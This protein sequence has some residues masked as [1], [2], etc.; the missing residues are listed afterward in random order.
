MEPYHLPFM[1]EEAAAPLESAQTVVLP[2]P[3]E[4]GV[5][6][7][8]GTK[9]A[10]D[11]I[12]RASAY[13]ELYDEYLK[14]E[15]FK[16]GI[17]TASPPDIPSTPD[18][19]IKTLY[20]EIQKLTAE[21]KQVLLLGGDHSISVAFVKAL[22]EK[23][24]WLSVIQFDAHADLRD[25]Y[26]DSKM[27]H[28]CVMSRIRELTGDT[29]QIGVRSMCIEE[30]ELIESQSIPVCTMRAFREGSFDLN[31]AINS[32]P[33]PVYITFDVDVFDWSVVRSTGTP[34]PGGMTWDEVTEVLQLIAAV[35]NVVGFDLV[36]LSADENDTPSAFA[37]A[38]LA[39]R[40]I[41]MFSENG[42]CE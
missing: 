2:F 26:E 40:M 8:T 12:L 24:G 41:G 4:G 22:I 37:V 32:L 3:Y 17:F 7:G 34:E 28:A 42:A 23:H 38:K 6:Y 25:S 13:I 19:M 21:K 18:G 27:S 29:L 1:G 15:P 5:S 33:D 11:A 31:Q 30:A 35:R 36:E 39:Y 20:K 10:P 14:Q 16:S 9:E